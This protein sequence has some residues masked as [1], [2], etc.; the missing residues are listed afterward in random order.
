MSVTKSP[1]VQKNSKVGSAVGESSCQKPVAIFPVRYSVDLSAK[2]SEESFKG[3]PTL[4]DKDLPKL[5][6]AK[7]H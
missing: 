7:Y 6:N 1:E 5:K 3:L 4:L 2:G